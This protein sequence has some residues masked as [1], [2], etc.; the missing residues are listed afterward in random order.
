MSFKFHARTRFFRFAE[1]L[2]WLKRSRVSV[3]IMDRTYQVINGSIRTDDYDDA[4]LLALGLHSSRVIDVGC[5]VGQSSLLLLHS[6]AISEILLVD[7]NPVAL[8]ICA[9]NLILNGFS[10]KA[11][12]IA[13][14]VSD[15]C[16][17]QVEFYTVGAGAAGSMYPNHA[18]TARDLGSVSRVRTITLD[19]LC[20][21]YGLVPDLVKID[22][23]GA[24][25]GVL[26]GARGLASKKETR[27]IVEMHSNPE[28]TMRANLTSVL[29]W[30]DTCG[31]A[32][33]YLKTKERIQDSTAL[34]GRGRCHVLLLPNS[35]AFPEFLRGLR[36][37]AALEEVAPGVG[38]S[39]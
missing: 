36:Q 14:F 22:V 8:S 24:E 11:R 32:A 16:D 34:D 15:A 26:R 1:Q 12:F 18:V 17:N 25:S 20:S 37:G 33:W 2:G 5:N 13:A 6:D 27:F 28:L 39:A 21:R 7:P 23:E 3:R 10:P 31:Y 38:R 29:Q 9:E 19:S 35:D 4:W 30:C